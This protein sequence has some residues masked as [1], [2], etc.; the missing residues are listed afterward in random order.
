MPRDDSLDIAAASVREIRILLVLSNRSRP[1]RFIRQSTCRSSKVADR[2][3]CEVST[4]LGSR[5]R[6][7]FAEC[8]RPRPAEIPIPSRS[9]R[10]PSAPPPQ[11][12]LR[13]ERDVW[14]RDHRRIGDSM[15]FRASP[16]EG[17]PSRKIYPPTRC[18]RSHIT[19]KT[20]SAIGRKRFGQLLT[21]PPAL[22]PSPWRS[23][24]RSEKGIARGRPFAR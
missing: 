6:S 14:S 10:C 11:Y 5:L 4:C 24:D 9:A 15:F 13:C 3:H 12:R 1:E 21:L 2:H 16:R 22:A 20:P 23:R 18:N 8:S 7:A 17:K 19:I